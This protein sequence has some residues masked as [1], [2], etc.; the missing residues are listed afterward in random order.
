VRNRNKQT[1]KPNKAIAHARKR[2]GGFPPR[3]PRPLDPFIEWLA[4]KARQGAV[5]HSYDE[6]REAYALEQREKNK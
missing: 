1:A 4:D 3:E 2:M 6:A 5:I